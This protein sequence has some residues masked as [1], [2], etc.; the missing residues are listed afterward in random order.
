[1]HPVE[2]VLET[3]IATIARLVGAGALDPRGLDDLTEDALLRVLAGR[4]GLTGGPAG[5]K[6]DTFVNRANGPV[7][8]LTGSHGFDDAVGQHEVFSVICYSW[9]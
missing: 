9:R 5:Q 7:L 4:F 3:L 2:G 6:F 8:E 1:M